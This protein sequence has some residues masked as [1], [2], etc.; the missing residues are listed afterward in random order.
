MSSVGCEQSQSL[1]FPVTL[2]TKRALFLVPRLGPGTMALFQGGHSARPQLPRFP[3]CFASRDVTFGGKRVNL[4]KL[5]FFPSSSP[6]QAWGSNS[7]PF[8]GKERREE[9]RCKIR[10][11]F[12]SCTVME[13]I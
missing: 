11:A 10:L 1:F 6:H 8:G 5:Y 9:T 4:C 3:V 7:L 12:R 2:E 13:L